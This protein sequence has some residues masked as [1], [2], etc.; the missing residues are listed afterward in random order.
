MKEL[1]AMGSAQTKKTFMNHGAVEPFFGVKVG[2]MKTIVKKV[3]RNYELSL[4]LF[5]TGNADAMYLAGLISDPQKMTKKDLQSWADKA[6]WQMI[7]EY[8][9]PWTTSESPYAMEMAMKW[10]DSPKEKIASA[11]WTT[12]SSYIS[13]TPNEQID[14]KQFKSLIDRVVKEI[15]GSDNRVRYTMNAFIISAGGYIP[16]LRDHAIKASNKIGEVFVDVGKTS[17]KVPEA[18]S[19]IEKMAANGSENKKKKTAKC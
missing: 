13:I 15:H 17:C 12:L 6:S 14:K 18:V 9:V 2:D 1:E 5:D 8:A 3:K 4:E 10:I 7:S 11:G 16:E 19:Y